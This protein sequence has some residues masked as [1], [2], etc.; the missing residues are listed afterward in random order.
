MPIITTRFEKIV[1]IK[2]QVAR[3]EEIDFLNQIE[4]VLINNAKNLRNELFLLSAAL[5]H[6]S[7]NM[8]RPQRKGEEI[9]KMGEVNAKSAKEG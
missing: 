5:G 3:S 8:Q 6:P 7:S 2:L 4:P 9:T 1:A